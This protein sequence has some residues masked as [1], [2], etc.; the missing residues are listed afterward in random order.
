MMETE[1]PKFLIVDSDKYYRKRLTGSALNQVYEFHEADSEEIALIH[2]QNNKYRAVSVDLRIPKLQNQTLNFPPRPE[3]YDNTIRVLI[4]AR[5]RSDVQIVLTKE[6][7][8]NL[9]YV[10]PV[11]VNK[12]E[13][14]MT[15]AGIID[16]L[17]KE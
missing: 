13:T 10:Q 7:K 12:K 15:I 14:P 2:L 6:R 4:A 17:R 16:R 5:D 1:K 8:K 11:F 9:K 3:E